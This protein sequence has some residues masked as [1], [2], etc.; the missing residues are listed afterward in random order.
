MF[1]YINIIE[2]IAKIFNLEL[3]FANSLIKAI[4]KKQEL[5][6]Y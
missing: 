2:Q 3:T 4:K 5:Y 1:L 6:Y